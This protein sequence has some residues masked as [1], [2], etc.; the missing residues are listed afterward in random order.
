M[1]MCTWAAIPSL[2]KTGDV[3]GLAAL[4]VSNLPAAL[5]SSLIEHYNQHHEPTQLT[6]MMAN[7]ISSR[8]LATELDDFV[9]RH[10]VDRVIM[11]I[12]TA[13]PRTAQAIKHNELEV[14]GV[15]F[16]SRGYRNTLSSNECDYARCHYKNWFEYPY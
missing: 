6:M 9:E 2:V 16:T 15:L 4:T 1:K 8:G 10:M 14:G 5:L 7:D 11:S 3:I 12:M 13:S